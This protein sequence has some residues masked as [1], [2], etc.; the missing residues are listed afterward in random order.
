MKV[1]I[2][3]ADKAAKALKSNRVFTV[4]QVLEADNKLLE[5]AMHSEPE[6][7]ENLDIPKVSPKKE[8][9]DSWFSRP[10]KKLKKGQAYKTKSWK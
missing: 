5:V 1:K 2:L 8:K 9:S 3:D 6:A 4:G 10:N 7:F